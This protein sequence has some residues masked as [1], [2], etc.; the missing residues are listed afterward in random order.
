M[1][2]RSE[3]LDEDQ[4]LTL[5]V[6]HM[7]PVLRQ[8][9]HGCR[10]ETALQEP[11]RGAR[12]EHEQLAQAGGARAVFHV[13]EQPLAVALRLRIGTDDQAGHLG[14]AFGRERVER[15]AAE[16]HAVVLDHR[17]VVDLAFDQFAAALDQRAVRF[18]WFDQ[19][20]DAADVVDGRD[21]QAFDVLE[22]HH[23]ADAVVREQLQQRRAVGVEGHDVRALDAGVAGLDRVL[24]VVG[25]VVR[26]A[27]VF[28]HRFRLVRG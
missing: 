25:G 4:R 26:D 7:L 12:G 10:D 6:V 23:G 2:R 19:F 13:L 27:A 14:H 22:G 8:V 18:V 5:P 1:A 16:D 9:V 3:L 20:D 28:Q 24:Q 21:A 17:E 11:V 15:R